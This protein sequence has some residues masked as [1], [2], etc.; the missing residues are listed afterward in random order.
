MLSKEHHQFTPRAQRCFHFALCPTCG[1]SRHPSFP[2]PFHYSSRVPINYSSRSL[3]LISAL[4]RSV[5]PCG[6]VRWKVPARSTLLRWRKNTSA[7]PDSVLCFLPPSDADVS[8]AGFPKGSHLVTPRHMALSL[9]GETTAVTYNAVT[10][11]P[12]CRAQT[13]AGTQGQNNVQIAALG[14]IRGRYSG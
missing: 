2:R 1:L 5:Q 14:V 3:A 7:N 6:G 12:S 13:L 4:L 10:Q 8:A 9:T 11:S